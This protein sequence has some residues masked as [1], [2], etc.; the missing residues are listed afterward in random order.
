MKRNGPK[1]PTAIHGLS[2][3]KFLPEEN[4]NAIADCLKY[5]FTPHDLCDE[6]HEQR[7]DVLLQAENNT[8]TEIKKGLRNG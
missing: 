7:V 1:A 3:L 2:G 4:A 6:H 8:I 5:R